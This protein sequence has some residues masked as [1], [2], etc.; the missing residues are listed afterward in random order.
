MRS[1]DPAERDAALTR[2]RR[3]RVWIAAAVVG[4]TGL[5]SAAAAASFRGHQSA[6]AAAPVPRFTPQPAPSGPDAIPLP[7]SASDDQGLQPPQQ[8]PEPAPAQTQAPTTSGG[9]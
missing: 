6:R 4:L 2:L 9:T 8:T 7:P 3:A 5:A 1:L